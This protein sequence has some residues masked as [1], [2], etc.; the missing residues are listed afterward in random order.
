MENRIKEQQ[1]DLFADRTSA[2]AM[3]ANQL[4]LDLSSA[5]Y[6]L[7]HAL[8]RLGLTNTPL[9][10][11]QCQTIRLKLLRIGAQI[12][13][14]VRQRLDLDV[15]GVSL[16]RNL[17]AHP[18]EPA[19]DSTSL[20]TTRSTRGR[21]HHFFISPGPGSACTRQIM[22]LSCQRSRPHDR[23]N[24]RFTDS[25]IQHCRESVHAPEIDPFH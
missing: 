24:H 3:R 6:M 11:A 12:R 13:I 15:G 4:R 17:R 7:M 22:P 9:A 20:L 14:T 18:P 5:A 25:R 19:G 1:L 8:R 2:A 21:K 10:R 23:D 16:C